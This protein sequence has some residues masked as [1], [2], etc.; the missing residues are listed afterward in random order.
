[1]RRTSLSDHDPTERARDI[2]IELFVTIVFLFS[3][4]MVLD[5][6][7]TIALALIIMFLFSFVSMIYFRYGTDI[8]TSL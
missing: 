8:V 4:R 7:P 1:M 2:M 3:I 6:Y 5:Y